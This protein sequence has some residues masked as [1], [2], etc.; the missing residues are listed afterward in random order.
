MSVSY[1]PERVKIRLWGKA[2]GRC[3]YEGCNQPLW[4]DR[5]TKAEFNISYIA[6]IVGDSVDGPRGDAVLSE[7]LKCDL[8]NLMLLC[9]P[10][11]RLVDR[12]D[13]VGHPVSRLRAMKEAHEK[14]IE[15]ASGIPP[16]MSSHVLLYGANIGDHTSPVSYRKAVDAMLPNRYPAE[17][18][19]ISLGMIN[20]AFTDKHS[21]F[22]SI[23]AENLRQLIS[24][25]LRPRLSGGEI[26][27]L[28]IFGLAPQPLLTLLGYSLCDIP[29]AEVFQLHR[30]PPNWS[31]QEGPENFDYVIQEPA[32][33]R[34]I[35]ALVLSLSATI[36]DDRIISVLGNGVAIWRVTI[37]EPN[38]DF[39]KS[40]DQTALFRQRMRTLLDRMKAR[41]GQNAVIHVFPAM[42]A[43]LA[44]ELGRIVMP[45]ADLPMRLYDENRR[46]GGFVFAL[47]IGGKTQ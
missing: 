42:P 32:D 19:P 3:E 23:E 47:E 8:S 41:H 24:V 22:W 17:L 35:P 4:L 1:I 44:L 31:W 28:S 43:A 46:L 6:H 21:D 9:D 7:Q 16:S 5:L 2:A 14:R 40:A 26:Q 15:L 30:E 27:H 13:V 45:K 25:R 12:E 36:K 10:H 34:G 20:S 38:N 33:S 37:N 39:L 18:A 11:H 29:T